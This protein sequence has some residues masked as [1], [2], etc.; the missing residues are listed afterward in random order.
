MNPSRITSIRTAPIRTAPIRTAPIRTLAS[1]VAALLFLGFAAT[2]Q[3]E[4]NPAKLAKKRAKALA[5]G[6]IY[7]PEG[8]QR[9]DSSTGACESRYVFGYAS[10]S[11]NCTTGP[12]TFEYVDNSF[13][14]KKAAD[15]YG[16]SLDLAVKALETVADAP[17]ANQDMWAAYE[18]KRK[19][20]QYLDDAEKKKEEADDLNVPS[21][22]VV[23]TPLPVCDHRRW[24]IEF[25]NRGGQTSLRIQQDQASPS[26]VHKSK[27]PCSVTVTFA[28]RN[29]SDPHSSTFSCKTDPEARVWEAPISD[30]FLQGVDLSDSTVTV[31]VD[32]ASRRET[33]TAKRFGSKY[34]YTLADFV[35]SNR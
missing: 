15:L 13:S 34:R 30:E 32:A 19:A 11:Y 28:G 23:S 21:Y 7:G 9:C 18:A 10:E 33:L 26:K 17:P 20:D 35:I 3:A 5:S 27:N 24:D 22:A 2:L 25:V 8:Y 31:T 29:G 4:T 6:K 12:T 14:Q 1:L 16:E